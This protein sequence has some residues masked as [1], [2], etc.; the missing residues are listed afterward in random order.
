MEEILSHYQREHLDTNSIHRLSI[1][2]NH[3]YTDSIKAFKKG[4]PL[5]SSL[6]VTFIGEPGI[7]AGGLLKEYLTLLMK[8]MMMNNSLFT[9]EPECRGILHSMKSLQSRLFFYVGQMIAASILNGG[10]GP[11]CMSHAI[12]DYLTYGLKRVN[13]TIDDVPNC[14]IQGHM[15]LVCLCT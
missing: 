3:I 15:K 14:V 8:D 5:N 11:G 4:F 13:A 10:P 9:G 1:R 12:V 2:R 7:D 6:R